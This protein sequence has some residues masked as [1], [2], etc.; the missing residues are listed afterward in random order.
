MDTIDLH[1]VKHGDV[2][3]IIIDACS[4]LDIPFV[5]IT[6]KSVMMKRIVRFAA[7]KQDLQ[8]R[9]HIC[10]PGRMIIYEEKSRWKNTGKH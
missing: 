10:N 7:E 5:V 9:D 4:K 3:S 1:G 6:G 2:A 8:A